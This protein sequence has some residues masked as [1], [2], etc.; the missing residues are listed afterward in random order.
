MKSVNES[1]SDDVKTEMNGDSRAMETNQLNQQQQDE[2]S[3][4]T[5]EEDL[6]WPGAI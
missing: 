4:V 5:G 1:Q 6:E 3:S 2:F